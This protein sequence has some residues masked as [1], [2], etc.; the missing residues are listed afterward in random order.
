MTPRNRN[1]RCDGSMSW[2]KAE[3]KVSVMAGASLSLVR[4]LLAGS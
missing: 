2:K 4:R 3:R 1:M